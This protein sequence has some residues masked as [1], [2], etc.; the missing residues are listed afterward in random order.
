MVP[1][2][3]KIETVEQAVEAAK[4]RLLSVT[5][6][7]GLARTIGVPVCDAIDLLQ[8]IQDAWEREAAEQKVVEA[9]AEGL[10]P[11]E[12][13]MRNTEEAVENAD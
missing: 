11:E 9:P 3:E 6:P 13:E 2:Q 4:R 1:M 10:F 7:A 5:V 8:S 12:I